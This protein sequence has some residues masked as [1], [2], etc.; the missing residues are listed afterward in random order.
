MRPILTPFSRNCARQALSK[1]DPAWRLRGRTLAALA[2]LVGAQVLIR[3]VPLPRWRSRLG[4]AGECLIHQRI[5]ARRLAVHVERAA[6]RLPWG[7]LCLPQAIALSMLLKNKGIPHQV[8]IAIR[9]SGQRGQADSLHAW[10]D[11]G[12]ITVLGA[13]AGPWHELARLP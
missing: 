4:L 5:E 6:A 7:A 8:V 9:P 11:C 1:A 13:L 12:G 3:I 2:L 10:V